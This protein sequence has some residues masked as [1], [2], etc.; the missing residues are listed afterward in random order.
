MANQ[1]RPTVE[2]G[3][4]KMRTGRGFSKKELEAAGATVK[5]L[6]NNGIL[7]DARRKS[8]RPENVEQLKAALGGDAA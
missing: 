5:D 3:N 2:G 7:F 8:E 4:G 1:V 6:K